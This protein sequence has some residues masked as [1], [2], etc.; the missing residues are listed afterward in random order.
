MS[1]M[2]TSSESLSLA[3][4]LAAASE[5]RCLEIGAGVNASVPAVFRKQ[6]GERPAVLVAD[7]NTLRAAGE[8]VAEA[9]RASGQAMLPPF[10]FRQPDLY[11]EYRYVEELEAALRSHAA[12]P[13]AVGS[14]TINDLTKLAS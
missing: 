1:T 13:V 7:P 4:A 11:A 14:G 9:F 5:T 8:A 2:T 6:F 3:E 10:I 12:I